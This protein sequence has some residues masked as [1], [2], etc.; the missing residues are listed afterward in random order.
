M[1]RSRT[2]WARPLCGGN[3]SPKCCRCRSSGADGEYV[4][5]G[6]AQ[7][8]AL[9]MLADRHDRAL[10]ES[11]TVDLVDRMTSIPAHVEVANA[12]SRLRRTSLT[13]VALTNSAQPVAETQLRN[14]GIGARFDA[15]MS[16]DTVKRLKPASEPYR[17]AD[18]N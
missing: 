15:V 12:L 2:Y 13:I 1:S 16:A 7:R 18:R 3:S 9:R 10:T 4:D 17:A 11:Q 5:F 8:A 14:A 6:T